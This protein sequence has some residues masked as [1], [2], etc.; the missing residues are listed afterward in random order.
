MS[1]EAPGISVLSLLKSDLL[2][3]SVSAVAFP[4][5]LSLDAVYPLTDVVVFEPPAA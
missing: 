4:F 1:L 2:L 5:L 3:D